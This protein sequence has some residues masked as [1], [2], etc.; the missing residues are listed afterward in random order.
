MRWKLQGPEVLSLDS[1]ECD[2]L[3]RCESGIAWVTGDD[4]ADVLLR[5]GEERGFRR[6]K[7]VVLQ[8]LRGEAVVTSLQV[9]HDA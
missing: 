8:A 3:I 9:S 7:R 2:L 1:A 4:G 5:G 6:G